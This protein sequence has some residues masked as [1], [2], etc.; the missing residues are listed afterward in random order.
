[1]SMDA[2]EVQTPGW[3]E[4]ISPE[5]AVFIASLLGLFLELALI[6]WVSS[7]VRVFAYCKNLVLVASFLGFGVGCMRARQRENLPQAM[8]LLLLLLLLVQLP[9]QAL[10]EYGP[11]RVTSIF[12]RLSGMMIFY[13][14][15]KE[16]IWTTADYGWLLFALSWTGLLFL[17]VA[18]IMVPFGQMTGA[19]L[20]RIKDP[21][22]GY[23]INVLG[24]LL[25]I[26]GYTFTTAIGLPPLLW[27]VPVVLC[28]IWL[29][30][31]HKTTSILGIAFAVLMVM[32]PNDTNNRQE[33]WSGYQKLVVLNQRDIVVNNIAYQRIGFQKGAQKQ[34]HLDR[35]AA[36]Y[37]PFPPGRVLIVGAGA[38]NDAAAALASGA[39]SVTAVEIDA[40][41]YELG[42]QLH[43][44]KPYKDK[45]VEVILDDARHF[46][47]TTK[48]TF[49]VIVFSHLDSH[50][51]LS[52]YTNVRLDNYIYTVEAF[53]EA[54]RL[55]SPKGFVYVSFYAEK[56][57]VAARLGHNL[58]KAF[59]RPPL[60][61]KER[62]WG[63]TAVQPVNFFAGTPET[64]ATIAKKAK[65]WR[66]FLP[67]QYEPTKVLP[68]TDNWPFLPL[69]SPHIPMLVLLIS[70]VA[71]LASTGLVLA[72]RPSDVLF[73]GRLFWLGAAFMLLEVHNVS[74]LALVFGTTWH[75]NA[76]VIGVILSLILLANVLC[77][78][79]R[80]KGWRFGRWPVIGLF[81]TLATAYL[82][83]L[84]WLNTAYLGGFFAT[85]LMSL[86]IFFAGIIFATAFDESPSPSFAL[87]WNVLGSV[88][89]GL[90]ESLS[91]IFGIPFLV[92]IAALFYT[93]ALVWPQ[94]HNAPDAPTSDKTNQE[95]TKAS[96]E[97]EDSE[98]SEE[99]KDEKEPEASDL[100]PSTNPT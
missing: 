15:T 67:L 12:A 99:T 17:V 94:H 1:M 57:F 4:R 3:E 98:D 6:R 87:G 26:L 37:A 86:P 52:S 77:I 11:K 85:V 42:T 35:F 91:Y 48:R 93:L 31:R 7:E 13:H 18:L 55:L 64:L 23:S 20:S 66:R 80:K 70:L 5:K 97:S 59:G 22:R 65:S 46:L 29:Q 75:V 36:P 89:G 14:P 72:N 79:F 62:G 63:H 84:N 10:L 24:S 60:A 41:I 8:F 16:V 73:D 2:K 33:Y 50:I 58:L 95:E 49:D 32:A 45:R 69:K 81:A 100:A 38:G 71:F 76:W 51:V 21:L 83:P 40:K 47:K 54:K 43:P 78:T 30:P 44:Q 53:Q 19:G 96:E 9:N 90:T 74:R 92:P 25:G 61:L 68:S 39:K 28:G 56:K 82:I 88:V 27:F 34:K